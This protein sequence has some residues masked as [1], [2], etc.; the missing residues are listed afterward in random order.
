LKKIIPINAEAN[1][2]IAKPINNTSPILGE[3]TL[4]GLTNPPPLSLY[5]HIAILIHTNRALR[6][7]KNAM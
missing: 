4:S 2:V 1:F 3:A 6:Y 7:L 5:I